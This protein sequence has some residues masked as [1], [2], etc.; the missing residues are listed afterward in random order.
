MAIIHESLGKDIKKLLVI[1]VPWLPETQA[2]DLLLPVACIYSWSTRK[3]A[4]GVPEFFPWIHLVSVGCQW[5]CWVY[6]RAGW[7]LWF[8]SVP[9]NCAAS[10]PLPA[11]TEASASH[12]FSLQASGWVSFWSQQAGRVWGKSSKPTSFL[13]LWHF[14]IWNGILMS[15]CKWELMKNAIAEGGLRC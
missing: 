8:C 6:L 11:C 15:C 12:G 4:Q 13:I 1:N 3:C 14:E 9:W 10:R 7:L 5:A 2:T